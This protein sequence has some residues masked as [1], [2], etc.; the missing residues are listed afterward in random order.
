MRDSDL[1][2]EDGRCG[3]KV[4]RRSKQP[5]ILRLVLC[6][7]LLLPRDDDALRVRHSLS[8]KSFACL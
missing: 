3:L 2:S 1:P 4:L 8:R 6:S 5:A 7:A